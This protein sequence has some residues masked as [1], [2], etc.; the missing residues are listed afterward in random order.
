MR[1]VAGEELPIGLHAWDGS[2]T[3]PADVPAIR[4]N[5][6]RVLARQLWAPGELGAAQSFVAGELDVDGDLSEALARVWAAAR[7]RR[8]Q[9][10]RAAQTALAS[11]AAVRVGSR[12]GSL[13]R[14]PIPDSQIRV[15][16]RL[17]SRR[18][19]RDVV[20]SH[21]DLSNEFYSLVLD[22]Q[23]A[24][25]C[26]YFT[27]N[28]PGAP[29]RPG[30]GL[31]DAQRD[32]FDLVC[33]KLGLAPGM[34]LLDVGCGWGALAAHAAE[35]Y[36]CRVV[37]ITLSV[38]QKAYAD[39]MLRRRGLAD[40]VE[41]R[42]C[43]YRELKTSGAGSAASG[44]NT[45]G[46]F[47][48]VVSLEMGEHV[49]QRNY[50]IYARVLHDQ[51]RPGGRVLIQQMSRS[52]RHQ[53]GG[54]FIESFIAPDMTMRPVGQTIDLLAGSGLEIRDVQAMREHYVW[55]VD[56]WIQ[57]FQRN[58]SHVVDLVGEEV[59]RVWELYLAGGRLSFA[60]GRMGVDQ[61]LAV[62][63]VLGDLSSMPRRAVDEE[64]VNG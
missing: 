13:R 52:G 12:W 41:I 48:A 26:A 14:P 18:R 37:G 30:Y 50:R 28:V 19:D 36:G 59:A 8:L 5:T 16:G 3:G 1:P 25:S 60:E 61:I 34:T 63:P 11:L 43:D 32:K 45:T 58:R 42:L 2:S 54:P 53:G 38:Q 17:H 44:P 23:M 21:Y 7:E 33:T 46:G 35:H 6:A 20:A 57:R 22:D 64:A 56:A 27:G 51:V 55:T 40:V 39:E 4:L 9:P 15:G 29:S 47:D 49:G 62:R 24:Y 10:G 31:A